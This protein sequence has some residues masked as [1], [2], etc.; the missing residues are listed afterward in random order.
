MK[1]EESL[2]EECVK[3]VAKMCY[4]LADLF[5]VTGRVTLN[6]APDKMGLC[7]IVTLPPIACATASTMESPSP[8]CEPFC[9]SLRFE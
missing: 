9:S 4:F 8:E 1:Y 6:N 3:I 2:P 5:L 7:S